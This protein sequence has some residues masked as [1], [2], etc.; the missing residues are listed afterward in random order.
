MAFLGGGDCDESDGEIN[1]AAL[2]VPD[3]GIDEDCSGQD[4]SRSGFTRGGIFDYPVS[5]EIPAQPNVVLIT[6]D[7]FAAANASMVI[8]TTLG[9]AGI[10]SDT[11]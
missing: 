6:I 10:S 7:A 11:G 2:D 3:N 1:P 9:C 4:L 8:S 5:E